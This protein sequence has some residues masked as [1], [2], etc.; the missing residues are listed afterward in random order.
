MKLCPI[1]KKEIVPTSPRAN[2]KKFYSKECRESTY[3]EYRAYWQRARQEKIAQTSGKNKLQ[4]LICKRYYRRVGKHIW[5]THEITARE[6]RVMQHMEVKRGMTT[7][8]DRENLREH[9][10]SNGTVDNLKKGKKNW[11]VKG[12]KRAGRYTRSPIAIEKIKKAHTFTKV[13]INKH[14]Q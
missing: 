9:V 8:Q 10:F 1:C 7:Q 3:K 14:K 6:Y 4:C 13:Y 11:F 2:N 5:N 12:D